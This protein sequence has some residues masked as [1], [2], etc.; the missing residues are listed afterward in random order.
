VEATPGQI[1]LSFKCTTRSVQDGSNLIGDAEVPELALKG[2]KV[3][4]S[5]SLCH[6]LDER[7]AAVN[8][9]VHQIVVWIAPVD[10]AE[11]DYGNYSF[12][13]HEQVIDTQVG[14]QDDRDEREI[15]KRFEV[16][17]ETLPQ[18]SCLPRL[19]PRHDFPF[20]TKQAFLVVRT[21]VLSGQERGEFRRGLKTV[22]APRKVAMLSA[23]V[24]RS[25]SLKALK[26]MARPRK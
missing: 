10:V 15:P 23:A 26:A 24:F 3:A 16:P 4:V 22:E 21:L 11:I 14:A 8:K 17:F 7:P 12:V 6:L 25:S 20:G 9:Q 2:F 13:P 5:V 18:G 19:Q 1:H